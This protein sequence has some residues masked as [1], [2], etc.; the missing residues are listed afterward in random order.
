MSQGALLELKQCLQE[1]K[2]SAAVGEELFELRAC[3]LVGEMASESRGSV[4][5]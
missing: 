5:V 4:A 1:S 3:A 2:A